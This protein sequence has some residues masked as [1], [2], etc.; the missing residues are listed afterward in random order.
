MKD[1]QPYML[2]GTPERTS[3]DNADLLNMIEF[4]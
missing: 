4:A 1:G 3:T 2:M